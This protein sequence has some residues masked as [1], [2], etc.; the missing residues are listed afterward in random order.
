MPP[1]PC[2]AVASALPRASASRIAA[3]APSAA[4]SATVTRRPPKATESTRTAA[5]IA[6]AVTPAR[7][8]PIQSA[9]SVKIECAT[10]APPG[11]P[12]CPREERARAGAGGPADDAR[13]ERD[14]DDLGRRDEQDLRAP[15]TRPDEPAAHVALVTPQPCRGEHGE[16][17]QEHRRV[18]AEDEQ[19]LGG[20]AA[21]RANR[22][23]RAGRR[24]DRE[25]VRALLELRLR[26]IEP[27]VEA[28]ELPV[29]D[30][31]R[32]DGD[33]PAVG[34]RDERRVGQRRMV[35]RDDAVGEQDR[36]PLAAARAEV[37]GERRA[38]A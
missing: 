12:R 17:E 5:S 7:R 33:D 2:K 16:A 37:G 20:D 13:G 29:V 10:T 11:E 32:R 23:D 3:S 36:R 28:R 27:R 35:E 24:D 25:D 14:A 6:A 30:R 9:R 1:L 22:R 8:A 31:P 21:R 34:A 26:A 38:G 18:A 15:R 19:A 4:T